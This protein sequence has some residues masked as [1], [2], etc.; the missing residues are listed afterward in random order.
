MKNAT[1]LL[2]I[3]ICLQVLNA[4][5]Q[6]PTEDWKGTNPKTDGC[7]PNASTAIKIA[8]AAWLPVYGKMI[9]KEKPYTATLKND[10]LWIVKGKMHESGAEGGTAY[11]EISKKTGAIY[12]ITHGE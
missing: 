2:L 11:I 12:L 4:C 8:E 6:Q 1:N 7:V 3:C 5:K 9:L 10:S